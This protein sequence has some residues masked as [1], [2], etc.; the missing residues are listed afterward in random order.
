MN[1]TCPYCN[2]TAVLATMLGL[3]Y[4]VCPN[5]TV[6][7]KIVVLTDPP[8]ADDDDDDYYESDDEVSN[9]QKRE[10]AGYCGK[11]GRAYNHH[12]NPCQCN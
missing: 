1:A 3:P 5:C 2:A 10:E 11:C 12:S 4:V 6:D 9:E 7:G 8:D